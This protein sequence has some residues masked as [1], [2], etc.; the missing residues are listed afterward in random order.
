MAMGKKL[1]VSRQ[2]YAVSEE[3]VG[4][5]GLSDIVS[6]CFAQKKSVDYDVRLEVSRLFVQTRKKKNV[7]EYHRPLH[8][9]FVL[10]VIK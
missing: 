2:V 9:S 1:Y 10:V 6:K 3:S 8:F 7:P 5:N 4:E